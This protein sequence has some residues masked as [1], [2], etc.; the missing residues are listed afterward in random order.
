MDHKQRISKDAVFCPLPKILFIRMEPTAI[1]IDINL[2]LPSASAAKQLGNSKGCLQALFG[3][4]AG[5]AAGLVVLQELFVDDI[6]PAAGA[7]GDIVAGELE[8]NAP[9][10]GALCAMNFEERA[11]F[12]EDV[13]EAASLVPRGRDG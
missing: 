3:V 10:H 6:S 4:E 2:C 5:I 7:L 12:A 13:V 11:Y 1:Q 9:R 8:V